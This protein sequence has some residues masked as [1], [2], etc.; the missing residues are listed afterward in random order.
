MVKLLSNSSSNKQRREDKPWIGAI[1]GIGCSKEGS[2]TQV[3]FQLI[4][5]FPQKR[6]GKKKKVEEPALM[7]RL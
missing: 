4:R 1:E 2:S 5:D 7:R 6:G 3:F